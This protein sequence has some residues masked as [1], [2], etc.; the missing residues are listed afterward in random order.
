MTKFR[1]VNL[2]CQREPILT[3][4]SAK[5]D[6]VRS[7]EPAYDEAGAGMRVWA[8]FVAFGAIVAIILSVWEIAQAS[9]G[10]SETASSRGVDPCHRLSL[11]RCPAESGDRHRPRL[12]GITAVDAADGDDART[13]RLYRRDFRFCGAWPQPG[14][15]R[16][17]DRR[18]GEEH[19]RSPR[20]N[21]DGRGL[22]ARASRGAIIDWPWS[23]IRWPRTSS[24]N[25]P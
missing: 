13:Q 24:S 9:H 11:G 15:A 18:H 1:Y 20:G 19:E 21:P 23:D 16:G 4:R 5:S 10:L 7:R 22:R 14:A 8:G 17:R 12:C 25:I 3:I 6:R 2:G